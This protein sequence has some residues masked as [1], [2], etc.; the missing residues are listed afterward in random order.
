MSQPQAV[1]RGGRLPVG[2]RLAALIAV[3]AARMLA[4]LPPR[5]IRAVLTL[6]RRRAT[7]ATYQQAKGAHDA[8]LAVSVLYGGRYCLQRSLAIPQQRTGS[9]PGRG[10]RR[11]I[12]ASSFVSLLGRASKA[13]ASGSRRLRTRTE[14]SLVTAVMALRANC[15]PSCSPACT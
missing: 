5:R 4:Y 13:A 7:L 11:A 15:W 14:L 8:I 9:C 1:E 6:L 10:Y 3:S 2:Q 12:R